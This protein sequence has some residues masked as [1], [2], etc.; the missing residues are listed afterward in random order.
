MNKKIPLQH[1][2]IW[3]ARVL[4]VLCFLAYVFCLL[5]IRQEEKTAVV[6]LIG[7]FLSLLS[8]IIWRIETIILRRLKYEDIDYKIFKYG[9]AHTVID[10]NNDILLVI[11]GA[12]AT[13]LII[14]YGIV[15]EP[16]KLTNRALVF[17]SI[18]MHLDYSVCKEMKTALIEPQ[19]KE[20][21]SE[22]AH[23]IQSA[24][25]GDKE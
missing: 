2:F 9:K 25:G 3:L 23:L 11:A 1:F 8:F 16:H 5:F 22:S 14:K 6:V 21:L 4:Y 15:E 17:L 13:V 12:I 19:S 24:Q 20:S 7:F 10:T 18:A